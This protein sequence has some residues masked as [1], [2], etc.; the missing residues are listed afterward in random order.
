MSKTNNEI[1]RIDERTIS[2]VV[3]NRVHQ[4]QESGNLV[5]PADYSPENALSAAY[6]KLQ[7]VKDKQGRPAS[8]VCTPASASMA[9]LDMVVQGLS[10]AKNQCY[11]IVYGNELQLQ[12][13]YLGTIAVA[14]RFGGVKDV[15]A[16]VVYKGD[17]FEFEVDPE[18]GI[19]KVTRHAQSL[20]SING[21]DIIAAYA[22]VIRE[23]GPVYQEIM[24][25]SEIRAAWGQGATKGN[26]PAHKTF[27]QEMAKKTVI[28]R[29]LKT[30]VNSSS[31]ASV[32]ADAYNRTTANDYNRDDP[33]KVI[34]VEEELKASAAAA[35]F[36]TPAPAEPAEEE[37]D[38]SG[39]TD[40]EKEAIIAAEIAEA[41]AEAG[42]EAE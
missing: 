10:P 41:E 2:D 25:W 4:M 14:K 32:L 30:F 35:I 9:L 6:L 26:S 20:D 42:K 33:E 24:T 37:P 1:A 3:L 13:S 40:E 16:Q 21:G 22:T 27:A 15:F 38:T 19:R 18:T 28:N 23:E 11:F 17:G 29:A 36:G 7:E 34:D 12:R 8:V 39:L 5:I 31:D